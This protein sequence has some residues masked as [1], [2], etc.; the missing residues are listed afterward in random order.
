MRPLRGIAGPL[1]CVTLVLLVCAARA[2]CAEG[3]VG[4]HVDV[5]TDYV[6]R[7]ISQTLGEPAIQA[8]LHYQTVDGWFLGG[9]AS[10]VNLNPG[11][12]ATVEFNAYAGRAWSFEGPWN[13][14]VSAVQ[15]VYPN[16]SATLQYDYFELAAT[17][18]YQD[19]LGLTV[20][21][22]PDTSR[23]SAYGI[24]ENRATLAYELIGR[25]PLQPRLSL[26]GSAGYYDLSRLFGTGYWYGSTGLTGTVGQFRADLAYFVSEQEATDLFGT[27]IADHR[28]ALTLTWSF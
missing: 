9:W 13:A 25:W 16:D 23:F 20:A 6:F 2:A 7:G 27:D 1:R 10:T 26:T 17:L 14:R 5:T 15:Y 24:A 21:W 3:S 22:S 18:A 28:W 8:D 11:A 4:G 19:R 12:G